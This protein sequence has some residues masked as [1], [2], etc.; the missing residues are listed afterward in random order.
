MKDRLDEA[1]RKDAAID[2]DEG[3]F[4]ARVLRA[5]P[6]HRAPAR[7]WWTSALLI[8][9]AALG[10]FLAAAFLPAGSALIQGYIDLAQNRGMTSS[11]MAALGMV[12][13]VLV[14]SVVLA[15]DTD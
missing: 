1:L 9:A 10:S 7:A 8:G 5:L 4:T 13:A 6:P 3:G 2:L 11:A 12:V 14:S 15:T